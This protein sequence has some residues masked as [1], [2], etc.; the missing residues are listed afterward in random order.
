M[1]HSASRTY[2]YMMNTSE[3]S[4]SPDSHVRRKS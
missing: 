3:L 4:T 1:R 2:A